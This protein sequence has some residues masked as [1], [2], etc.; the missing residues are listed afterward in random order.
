MGDSDRPQAV[1]DVRV[2]TSIPTHPFRPR[3]TAPVEKPGALTRA[4]QG[5]LASVGEGAPVDP[6]AMK[7]RVLEPIAR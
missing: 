7:L 6:C 4:L 3:A 1:L 2:V 5:L